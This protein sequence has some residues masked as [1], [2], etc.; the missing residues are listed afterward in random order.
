MRAAIGNRHLRRNELDRTRGG[1]RQ[2]RPGLS[3][4]QLQIPVEIGREQRGYL[5]PVGA[6][7]GMFSEAIVRSIAARSEASSAHP[8]APSSKRIV[9]SLNMLQG[10][11]DF[12]DPA[13]SHHQC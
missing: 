11:A 1:R 2:L 10:Y 9:A 12:D 13:I 7:R 3:R 6:N 8:T 5:L 4:R